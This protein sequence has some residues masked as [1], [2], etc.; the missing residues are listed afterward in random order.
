MHMV[1]DDTSVE[2]GWREYVEKSGQVSTRE[3]AEDH[4]HS[5]GLLAVDDING[6]RVD[7]HV[8]DL[9]GSAVDVMI[10]DPTPPSYFV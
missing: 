1:C 6:K 8:F 7:S 9:S 2:V 3:P 4:L 5:V 10:A